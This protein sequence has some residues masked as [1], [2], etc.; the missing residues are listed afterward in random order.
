[1]ADKNRSDIVKSI[2][3]HHMALQ[4]AFLKDPRYNLEAYQ[5]VCE[6]V[7]YTCRKLDGRRDV[8]G[9]ELLDG[10]CDLALEQFGFLARLVFHHWGIERTD[11]FGDIVFSLVDIGLLNKSARD[12]KADFHD[13]FP[14]R[15]ALDQRYQIQLDDDLPTPRDLA[16][17][18]HQESFE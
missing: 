6:A 14:L 4:N 5:F 9:R 13:V 7:D 2:V 18:P 16:I 17:W 8:S 15:Q 1:M 3:Q 11:A 10:I 12:S